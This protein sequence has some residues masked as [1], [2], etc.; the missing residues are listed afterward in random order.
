MNEQFCKGNRCFGS[1]NTR[2][3]FEYYYLLSVS[4]RVK[5]SHKNSTTN[6][7]ISMLFTLLLFAVWWSC[8]VVRA[9]LRTS[10][11]MTIWCEKWKKKQAKKKWIKCN[12]KYSS[13]HCDK[14]IHPCHAENML[15]LTWNGFKN[16]VPNRMKRKLADISTT[17]LLF[18]IFKYAC[19]NRVRIAFSAAMKSNCER[20][21]GCVAIKMGTIY[22]PQKGKEWERERERVK[23][24]CHYL[25]WV[26]ELTASGGSSDQS[27]QENDGRKQWIC[28]ANANEISLVHY[29]IPILLWGESRQPINPISKK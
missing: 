3:W 11:N 7:T 1:K 29:S 6:V 20:F 5:G 19:F 23:H 22:A 24:I 18:F 15:D 17:I 14:V 26:I 27:I 8:R 9:I 25:A 10:V 16:D 2:Y 12:M 4:S 21:Y 13:E 28:V